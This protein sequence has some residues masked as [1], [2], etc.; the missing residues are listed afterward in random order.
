MATAAYPDGH[1][2]HSAGLLTIEIAAAADPPRLE[3]QAVEGVQGESV[4]LIVVAELVDGDGSEIL[5]LE[6]T[7]LPRGAWLSAGQQGEG[8]RWHLKPDEL[9][10]LELRLPRHFNG[11][12]EIEVAALARDGEDLART[13]ARLPVAVASAEVLSK[14]ESALI[15]EMIERGDELMVKKDLVA[16]RLAMGAR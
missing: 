12:A 8:G 3:V 2:T 6:M 1:A 15:D 4:P 13:T 16:A 5:A 11:D 9:T 7:G 10:G 14:S